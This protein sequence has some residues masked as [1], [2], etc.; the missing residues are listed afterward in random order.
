MIHKSDEQIMAQ[1]RSPDV[2][3]APNRVFFT[4]YQTRNPFG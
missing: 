3:Y 1:P 4:K 2:S